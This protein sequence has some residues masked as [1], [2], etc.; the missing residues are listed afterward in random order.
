MKKS[1]CFLVPGEST[2]IVSG[3]DR[4]GNGR[5]LAGRSGCCRGTCRRP[6]GLDSALQ[7]RQQLGN[8]RLDLTAAERVVQGGRVPAGGG[9][10][11]GLPVVSVTIVGMMVVV[12]MPADLT[13][14]GIGPVRGLRVG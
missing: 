6:V 3:G 1:G 8:V 2:R 11:A 10:R 13:G 4:S 9:G 5:R 14:N 12:V 7:I